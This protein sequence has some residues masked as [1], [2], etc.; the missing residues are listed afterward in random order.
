MRIC[1]EWGV[2]WRE[3]GVRVS[4]TLRQPSWPLPNHT[5]HDDARPVTSLALP[6]AF[7]ALK[8]RAPPVRPPA[9]GGGYDA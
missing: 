4:L 3:R 5:T 8:D 2:V 1:W 6:L 9:G 7:A